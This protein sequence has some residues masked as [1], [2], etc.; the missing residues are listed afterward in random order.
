MSM[1]QDNLAEDFDWSSGSGSMS[2]GMTPKVMRPQINTCQFT[3]LFDHHPGSIVGDG[4][5]TFLGPNSFVLDI[6]S[7][8]VCDFLRNVHNFGLQ[9]TFRVRQCD[10]AV[11]DTDRSNFQNLTNAHSSLGHQFHHNPIAWIFRFENNFINQVFFNDFR[12]LRA[13]FS[14]YLS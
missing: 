4:E 10:L 1:P 8:S 6:F 7:K 12:L 3:R 13:L 11:F 2:R 14:E 9:A 5:N